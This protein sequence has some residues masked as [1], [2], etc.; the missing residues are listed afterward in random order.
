MVGKWH[1]LHL[2]RGYSSVDVAKKCREMQVHYNL[3]IPWNRVGIPRNAVVD[4]AKLCEAG[5]GWEWT[6]FHKGV[7]EMQVWNDG[8]AVFFMTDCMFG[9]D[10]TALKRSTKGA[11][12]CYVVSVPP[13]P[14]AFNV[15]GRSGC[16]S[17]DQSR[18]DV[19]TSPL[20]ITAPV[21]KVQRVC[22]F[23]LIFPLRTLSPSTKASFPARPRPNSSTAT[24][25]TSSTT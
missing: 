3:N 4:A 11:K 7:N 1:I 25:T 14:G 9:K 15:Y 23:S 18:K 10:V 21:E 17:S 6:C 8:T 16:D 24:A 2:D 20:P 5:A 19:T 22:C 13:G 12:A